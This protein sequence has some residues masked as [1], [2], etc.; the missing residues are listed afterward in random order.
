MK[1][2][3]LSGK[4]NSEAACG[5]SVHEDKE[6]YPYGLKLHLDEE[7]FSKLEMKGIP[8]VGDKYMILAMV[9]VSDTHKSNSVGDEVKVSM[10][11][12][13]TDLELKEHGEKKEQDT[14]T[15]LYG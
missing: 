4:H 9:E 5:Q 7:S 3:M 11:L 14:A 13:I 1:S 6:K 15:K 12:Q 8:K 2:M 10:G